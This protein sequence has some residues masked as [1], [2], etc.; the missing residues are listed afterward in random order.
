MSSGSHLAR[1]TLAVCL[2]IFQ[3]SLPLHLSLTSPLHLPHTYITA[4]QKERRKN[5]RKKKERR[6]VEEIR[7]AGKETRV[8]TQRKGAVVSPIQRAGEEGQRKRSGRSDHADSV[9]MR[10]CVCVLGCSEKRR[11]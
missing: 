1:L 2:G 4:Q 5:T 8:L 7:M 9:C 6:R 3:N 10:G 11:Y